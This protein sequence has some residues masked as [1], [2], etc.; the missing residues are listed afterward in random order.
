MFTLKFLQQNEKR[1]NFSD[2]SQRALKDSRFCFDL[3]DKQRPKHILV[4][5]VSLV[6]SPTTL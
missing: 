4:S 2:Q 6:I 1:L 3:M 5:S